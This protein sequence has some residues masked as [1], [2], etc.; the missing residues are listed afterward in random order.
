[1]LSLGEEPSETDMLQ[2]PDITMDDLLAKASNL[3]VLDEDGWEINEAGET[4]LEIN[5]RRADSTILGRVWGIADNNW[6][7]EIKHNNKQSSFLVFTFKSAQDLNRILGKN[8]WFLNYGT[9]IL[10]RMTSLPQD[11]EKEL[12]RFPICGR[13]YHLPSRSITQS[14][15]TRL[16]S[17]AGEVID[18]QM[19]DIPRIVTKDFFTFKVWCDIT[20]PLFPGLLFPSIGGKKWLPFRYERLPFMCFNCGFLGHDT[21][22]LPRCL[23]MD[24]AIGKK[25]YGPW[26]K[27]DDKREAQTVSKAATNELLQQHVQRPVMYEDSS[28]NMQNTMLGAEVPGA[29]INPPGNLEAVNS[30]LFIVDSNGNSFA[31]LSRQQDNKVP[32]MEK[33]ESSQVNCKRN[34]SWRNDHESLKGL[35]AMD[36][37]SVFDS[38]GLRKNRTGNEVDYNKLVEIPIS[39]DVGIERLNKEDRPLK[40]RKVTPRRPKIKGKGTT[41]DKLINTAG[42]WKINEVYSWFHKDDFP[43]VLGIIPLTSSPDW[44]SW[45]LNNNGKYSV[46]SGY[47]TR[48]IH[49]DLAECSNTA[50]LKAW[51]KFIW[52]SKLI[53]K[54]KNFI[55]RVFNQWLPTKIELSKRGMS[56]ETNCDWCQEKEEDI[57]HALWFCPKV[58][59]I[60]KL[61]GFDTQ[62]F[63]HMPK[64][65]DVLFYLWGKL[66]KE[67]LI[68]FIGLSWL[69]WQRRNI[70]I[71]KHQVQEIHSWVRWALE[72]LD[73]FFGECK[74]PRQDNAVTAKPKWGPP[75]SDCVMIN[76]DASLIDD[77]M[78][79]GLSVVLRDSV[80]DLIVAETVFVPGI[81]SI[82][83]AEA[84]AVKLGVR[85]AQKWSVSKAIVAADC[86]S[87][88]NSLQSSS[89]L[90]SYWGMLCRDILSLKHHFLSL[91]FTH[92][93]VGN[94]VSKNYLLDTPNA[95]DLN[96]GDSEIEE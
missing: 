8:P 4:L 86:L 34:G 18:V 79:Y 40:R 70:F 59:K 36:M 89:A 78:G 42:K 52:S 7:V 74:D 64:A 14:N 41:L 61:A 21:R 73:D 47:K 84:V 27:A 83:L 38:E 68:Q 69:I 58:L 56:L 92:F 39:Y 67:D 65:S 66:P 77:K 48:F 82:F 85:L 9:L 75:P 23:K 94:K 5:A 81:A 24:W 46:A 43:W 29:I 54:T 50:P 1:M 32:M 11:W 22:A 80:G 49:T 28:S 96:P 26:L 19:A 13:V 88:I 10:E 62:N 60:W 53:P 63:I 90:N 71:F 16:A 31:N 15:L 55:W 17:L 44:M 6:G 91:N 45:S 57:C 93:D 51:W 20:K 35:A 95:E 30:G 33:G 37:E 76:T 72:K 2:K 87:I 25:T 12:L 3:T